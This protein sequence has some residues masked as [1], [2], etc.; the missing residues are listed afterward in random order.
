[1]TIDA[2]LD[3]MREQCERAKPATRATY[4]SRVR[5]R[6]A[7]ERV[8]VPSWVRGAPRRSAAQQPLQMRR[9]PVALTASPA[10]PVV[11]L[12]VPAALSAW[13]RAG[14]G[15]VIEIGRRGTVL[16]ELGQPARRFGSVAEA[17]AAL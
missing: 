13:R 14:E 12:E 10:S 4:I 1:M 5:A 6:C 9:R 15:R 2:W 7:A 3:R 11:P 16:H 17:L 8:T